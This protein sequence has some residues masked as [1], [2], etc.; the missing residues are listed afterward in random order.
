MIF[1]ARDCMGVDLSGSWI[2]GDTVSDIAAGAAAG[3]AGGTLLAT[4]TSQRAKR[5]R[6][7]SDN[8]VV[9]RAPDLAAA[10]ASLIERGQLASQG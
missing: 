1:A 6:W 8:F 9:E 5:E 4:Q 7:R 3:L 10:V 2:I